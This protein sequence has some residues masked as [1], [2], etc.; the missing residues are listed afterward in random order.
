MMTK[1]ARET[2]AGDSASQV[3]QSSLS[4]HVSDKNRLDEALEIESPTDK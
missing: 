3:Q 1:K 4:K 2:D